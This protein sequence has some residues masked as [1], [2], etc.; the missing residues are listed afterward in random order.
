MAQ[1]SQPSLEA[2]IARLDAL[3][4]EKAIR[5]CLTRYMALCDDLDAGFDLD[6]LMDL[7]TQDAV[8]EGTGRYAATFGRR[9]GCDDIRAMFATYTRPPA[10]FRLNVHFLTSEDIA[11]VETGPGAEA[12]GRWVMLQTSTFAD[13]RSQLSAAKL[14]VRFRREADG[15]WRIAHFQTRRQFSRPVADPWDA[16]ADLPVPE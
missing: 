14:T 6:P 1:P 9:Q 11:V 2:V 4:A 13:G 15:T 3:E 10:H 12:D 8:W 7:F 16:D 5:A